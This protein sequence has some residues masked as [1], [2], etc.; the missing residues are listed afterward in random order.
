MKS[1]KTKILAAMTGIGLFSSLII[2]IAG[3]GLNFSS[4]ESIL[5]KS[6]AETAK[7]AASRVRTEIDR[8]KAIAS[9]IG[10][11]SS[12]TDPEEAES[13][14]AEIVA[15]RTAKYGLEVCGV[16]TIDG[17]DMINGTDCS[18]E[19]FFK[20]SSAG[21]EYC[22][23][24]MVESSFGVENAVI[25]SAPLW[26][27]GING[28]KVAGV[29]YMIPDNSF[30]N[31]IVTGINVGEG[32]TAYLL[33]SEGLTIAF[34]DP[35]VVGKENAQESAKTD[36]SYEK[37]AEVE[38]KMCAGETGFDQYKYNGNLELVAY[39]PV[40]G[41]PGWSIGVNVVRD[42][43]MG[44]TYT[45]VVISIVIMAVTCAIAAA[46]AVIFSKKIADPI[47]SCSERIVKLSEGDLTSSVPAVTSRDETKR[48]ADATSTVVSQLNSI[49]KDI[50][51]ILEEISKGNLAV[52][53]RENQSYYVGDYSQLIEY[54]ELI[55]NRLS[56]TMYQI[57]TAGE[58]VSAGSD[59]VSSGAQ[60]LAQGATEQAS[61]IEELAATIEVIAGQIKENAVNAEDA[62]NKTNAAGGEM[63]NAIS[64]MNDLVD[65]MNDI[66]RS[67]DETSKIIQTIEDI[68]FQTNILS[69]N[70][71]VEAA[72]AGEAGKGFA[73]VADEV[74]NLAG[75]SA[76]AAQNTTAL[77]ESTVSTIRRGTA[78]VD[79]VAEKMSSVSAAAGAVAEINSKISEASKNTADSISQ[80]TIGVEQISEV[81]QANSATSEQ[82]AAASE[83]LSSQA[84]TLKQLISQFRFSTRGLR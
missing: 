55:N 80:I 53:S 17:K 27:N 8:Y 34:H 20:V 61:S 6:M 57:N 54:I 46:I 77:I 76:V 29:V 65:A 3:A 63:Q 13:A 33:S 5:D 43:F 82:S 78:L 38:A 81:V 41:T 7:L 10:S 62:M 32:G 25:I 42:E 72:R 1:I 58:Q 21:D 19:E 66:I 50:E 31:D 37:L 84:N 12:L 4:A 60:A 28:G 36:P 18:D 30:L 16:L 23:D 22:S 67:S 83:E 15:E 11:V 59:Q 44:G 79:E 40:E 2:G 68:A 52:N 70:A 73:V 9:E 69:L 64:R 47:V 45:A 51:R 49:F 26:E 39:A 35:A 48:L 14:C 74:R 56:H 71:A 75:K 24:F